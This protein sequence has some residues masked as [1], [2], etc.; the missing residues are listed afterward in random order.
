MV[1]IAIP[2][3]NS[4]NAIVRALNSMIDQ[5][6]TNYEI[7]IVGD[8]TGASMLVSKKY[9]TDIGLIPEEYF[10]YMEE[11][12]WNFQGKQKGYNFYTIVSST[13][14]HKESISTGGRLSYVNIYYN[15]R[16]KI[17]F[18][19]KYSKHYSLSI[20]MFLLFKTKDLLKYLVLKKYNLSLAIFNGI[21]DG[22]G[23]KYGK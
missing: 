5:T 10:L 15:T 19:R 21:L 18:L 11:T 6:Y 9:I 22:I 14:F 23:H 20:I 3:Y 13:V 12:D 2:C 1:S 7:I 8:I 4:Q 17:Y 16:N